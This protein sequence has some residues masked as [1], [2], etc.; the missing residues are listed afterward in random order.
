MAARTAPI[1]WAQRLGYLLVKVDAGE[2]AGLL[3][4]Y[5][6]EHARQAAVLVLNAPRKDAGR[7]EAWKLIVNAEVEA[8]P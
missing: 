1:P 3:K 8:E 5:V 6:A 4:S 7:D 2:R